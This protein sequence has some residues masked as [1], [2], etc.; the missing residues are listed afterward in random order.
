[1]I[2]LIEVLLMI[3]MVVIVFGGGLIGFCLA[4][5]MMMSPAN[6]RDLTISGMWRSQFV[7]PGNGTHR[8]IH[9]GEWFWYRQSFYKPCIFIHVYLSISSYNLT[10]TFLILSDNSTG[11]QR[12]LCCIPILARY[13]QSRYDRAGLLSASYSMLRG[14]WSC[15]ASMDILLWLCLSH[16]LL[17]E[18]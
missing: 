18:L 16:Q 1:M 5:S 7:W 13:S 11:S 8:M 17:V 14:G 6:V 12:H 2:S 4:R 9:K 10:L 15:I 3:S